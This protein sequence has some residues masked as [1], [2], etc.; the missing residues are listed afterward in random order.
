MNDTINLFLSI[1]K[2]F[3]YDELRAV[4]KS[5]NELIIQKIT[6]VPTEIKTA[7]PISEPTLPIFTEV[8]E[9]YTITNH[10]DPMIRSSGYKVWID[11]KEMIY[12]AVDRHLE[13]KEKHIING[14]YDIGY[15]LKYFTCAY[16]SEN[17][18][19]LPGHDFVFHLVLIQLDTSERNNHIC[20]IK[21][22]NSALS[23]GYKPERNTYY[24]TMIS[25]MYGNT[26]NIGE[27]ITEVKLY[28]NLIYAVTK[29]YYYI[30]IPCMGWNDSEVYKRTDSTET[31]SLEGFRR[32]HGKFKYL[33]L[34]E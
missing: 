23:K 5:I 32:R 15:Y 31:E 18:H 11:K 33:W 25:G 1:A 6:I 13:A 20:S 14:F 30:L 3:N 7:E 19:G 12:V 22:H 16:H 21:N 2:N 29:S 17:T 10:I 24:Y 9:E 28:K 8:D 4:Q 26:F 34:N 27:E